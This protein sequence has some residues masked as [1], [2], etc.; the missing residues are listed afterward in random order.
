MTTENGRLFLG[1]AILAMLCLDLI[2]FFNIYDSD[3]GFIDH[4]YIACSH[5][6]SQKFAFAQSVLPAQSRRTQHWLAWSKLWGFLSRQSLWWGVGQSGMYWMNI[7]FMCLVHKYV[8]LIRVASLIV[9]LW[10]LSVFFEAMRMHL[11]K[12][13][14]VSIVI[15]LLH[16]SWNELSTLLC[17]MIKTELLRIYRHKVIMTSYHCT[18]IY[19][20][21]AF[22]L[23]FRL[24]TQ[25]EKHRRS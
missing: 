9:Y 17:Y 11:I 12:G 23:C 4:A 7:Y 14:C 8:Y 20:S 19:Q 18:F 15:I 3:L 25:R 6:C 16:S 24:G 13:M 2:C 22:G 21:I 1:K 10:N 5:L